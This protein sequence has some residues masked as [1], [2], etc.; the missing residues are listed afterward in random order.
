MSARKILKLVTLSTV[1]VVLAACSENKKSKSHYHAAAPQVNAVCEGIDCLSSINWKI[2]LQGQ[3][4][5]D[6]ARVDINGQ[7]VLDECMGKQQYKIDRSSVPQS[8]FLENFFVPKANNLTIQ[9]VDQGWDCSHERTFLL[10]QN[11]QF[12]ISKGHFG[13]EIEINL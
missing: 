11:I 2:N 4:F 7:T 9:V 12:E 5:P 13:R 6:K 8:L 1:L 10:D 3:V